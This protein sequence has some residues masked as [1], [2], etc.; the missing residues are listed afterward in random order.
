MRETARYALEIGE[1]PIAP[2]VMQ[3][4]EGGTEELTVIHHEDLQGGGGPA[5][6]CPF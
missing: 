6:T 1:D 3:A 2:F 5:G 4:A